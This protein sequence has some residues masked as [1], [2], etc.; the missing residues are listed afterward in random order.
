MCSR[1]DPYPFSVR[2]PGR[3]ARGRDGRAGTARRSSASCPGTDRAA[4]GLG[5]DRRPASRRSTPRRRGSWSRTSAPRPRACRS[6]SSP[7]RPRRTW[8]ASRRSAATTSGSPIRA[9]FRT[10]RRSAWSRAA[11]R[12]SRSTTAS[13]PTEV[14][15]TY[16]AIETARLL[17]T[18]DDPGDPRDPRQH[19]GADAPVAQPGRHAEGRGLV[20]PDALGTPFEGDE[21]AVPVPEVRRATTTTATGTCSRRRRAGSTVTH[22]YDRWRPQIVHDVH[23]MGTRSARMFLPPYVDPWEPNV[24]PALRAAVTGAGHARGRALTSEGR[25]GRGGQ[26]DLRRLEPRP[27]LSAHARR[28]APAV[29]G[30]VRQ[31]GVPD[32]RPV[33]R[34][35]A[36][37]R[38]RPE[39]RAP[40]TSPTPWLG[41]P[42][43]LRDIMDYQVGGEPRASCSTP[44]GTATTGCA[45]SCGVG[46]ARQSRARS[47]TRSCCRAATRIR[48]PPPSCGAC[49]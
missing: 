19:R 36:R 25:A 12:S 30:R 5:A 15:G 7:S 6:W 35:A 2:A 38:I 4:R 32:R 40:G 49:C 31:A 24:D 29:R 37:D 23:Q 41:G 46:P 14:A 1:R 8:R 27:R 48:W 22:V 17:A 33:R 11:R 39:G 45:R 28:R 18:A 34:P 16:A 20:P 47:P 43:R 44:R 21:P 26:R 9:G 42:W 10:P 13:T 3:A